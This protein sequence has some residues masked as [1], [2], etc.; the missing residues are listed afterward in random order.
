MLPTTLDT[1]ESSFVSDTC[2]DDDENVEAYNLYD[3]RTEKYMS[4][5]PY[6]IVRIT[7]FYC[8]KCVGFKIND[9]TKAHYERAETYIVLEGS[10]LHS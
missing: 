1:A 7:R 6:L 9:A 5:L 2:Q 3:K 4:Q 8:G 10:N